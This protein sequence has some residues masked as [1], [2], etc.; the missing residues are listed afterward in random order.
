MREAGCA[1]AHALPAKSVL[2]SA[3]GG[4]VEVE[5]VSLSS[6]RAEICHLGLGTRSAT[7]APSF[8]QPLRQKGSLS[9]GSKPSLFLTLK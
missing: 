1:E 4:A 6:P 8:K 2:R 7:G 9:L 3:R 5:R